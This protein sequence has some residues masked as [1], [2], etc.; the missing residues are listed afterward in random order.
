ML[1]DES[2]AFVEA[3]RRA[4]L[5]DVEPERPVIALRLQYV[6][7]HRAPQTLPLILGGQIEVFNPLLIRFGADRNH[8]R[9]GGLNFDNKRMRRVNP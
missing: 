3:S 4:A 6:A 9:R 7:Q 1:V 8:T 2:G 5:E